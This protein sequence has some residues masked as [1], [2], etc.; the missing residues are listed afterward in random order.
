MGKI[1]ITTVLVHICVYADISKWVRLVCWLI[2]QDF[3][4]YIPS[5]LCRDCISSSLDCTPVRVRLCSI[6]CCSRRLG[7]LFSRLPSLFRIWQLLDDWRS[8]YGFPAVASILV[9]SFQRNS[10]LRNSVGRMIFYRYKVYFPTGSY[11]LGALPISW[12]ITRPRF[13]SAVFCQDFLVVAV[14]DCLH[15]AHAAVAYLQIVTVE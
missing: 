11:R 15:I 3:R 2:D 7:L 9:H 8:R 10:F 14:D 1:D 4:Q 5:R 12:A 13:W 6:L